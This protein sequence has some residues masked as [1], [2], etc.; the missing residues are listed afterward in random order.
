MKA[1][2]DPKLPKL[3]RTHAWPSIEPTPGPVDRRLHYDLVP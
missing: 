3:Y 2:R 1:T